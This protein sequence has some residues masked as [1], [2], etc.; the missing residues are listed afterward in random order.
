MAEE[1]KKTGLMDGM[2]ENNGREDDS[3]SGSPLKY[4]LPFGLCKKYGIA[5][6][7]WWEPHDAWDALKGYNVSPDEEYDKLGEADTTNANEKDSTKFDKTIA[8]DFEKSGEE[9]QEDPYSEER[10]KNAVWCKN[11]EESLKRFGLPSAKI[12]NDAPD[13]EKEAIWQYTAGSGKFNRPLRGYDNGW[14]KQ[15]YKGVGNVDLDNEGAGK[16][17]E[18]MTKLIDKSSFDEDIWIQ[19]GVNFDGAK[20]FTRQFGKWNEKAVQN[21]IGEDFSDEAFLSGGAAKSTGFKETDVIFNIYCPKG[22]KMIYAEPF[23]AFGHGG[24]LSKHTDK[25]NVGKIAGYENEM[26]LQ[27]GLKYRI[28]KA[29]KGANGRYYIDM[30]V[31]ND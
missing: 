2:G 16:A 8:A 12:Y 6:Q 17:I 31:R 19:R 30:E 13:S 3:T 20:A 25:A 11:G 1:F 29:E 10:K 26:I 14:G 27:R 5:I 28:T 9:S 18:E 7:D 21:L 22:T 4:R 23:S 24:S 15:N